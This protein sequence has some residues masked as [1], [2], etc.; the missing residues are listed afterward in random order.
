[1][2]SRPIPISSSAP[3]SLCRLAEKLH[4]VFEQSLRTVDDGASY[5]RDIEWA[6]AQLDA[7][8]ARLEPH[9]R[10]VELNL[11]RPGD[12]Q[13]GRPYYVT[14]VLVGPHHPMYMPIEIETHDGVTRGC[15]TLD[16]TWEGPPDHVHGG[17]V[18]HLFDCVMGQHNLN[19][20]IPGMTGTLTIQYRR[21]TPL[22]TG[23]RFD[24]RTTASDGRK[25]TTEARLLADD[26]LIAE[27]QGFFVVP[28]NFASQLGKSSTG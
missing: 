28:A 12:P 18:A 5:A 22:H 25:I 16:I 19:V 23:L 20:G 24:V 4:E 26:V 8:G 9:A 1:M 14:G 13:R 2:A 17:F 7:I 10:Q 21:P 15:V 6:I 27:A 11:G 3:D